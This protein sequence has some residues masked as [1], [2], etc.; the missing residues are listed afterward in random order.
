M[1]LI[2]GCHWGEKKRL[3]GAPCHSTYNDRLGAQRFGPEKSPEDFAKS[4]AEQALQ[5]LKDRLEEAE[6]HS[7]FNVHIAHWKKMHASHL[8]F[9]SYLVS[10]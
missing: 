2:S 10:N 3:I 9:Q 5:S 6:F 1:G 8:I 4:A 7:F